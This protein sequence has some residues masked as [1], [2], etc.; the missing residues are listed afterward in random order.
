MKKTIILITLLI[1]TAL[2]AEEG[3]MTNK[4]INESS[5]YL[6]QHSHNPVDWYP[7][8]EE[9]F[10]TAKKEDKPV[11]L[12]IGYST[13]HWC[14]VMEKESFEDADVAELMN[15][16]FI[17][18]KV[19]REERPDIDQVYMNVATMLTGSGG[20]P[21]TIIMTPE[22]E[23]FFAGTYFPKNERFGRIGM[24]E[25]IPQIENAWN[26]K[27]EEIKKT[28]SEIKFSLQ[29]DI[30]K[31][32]KKPDKRII[33]TAFEQLKSRFDK[34]KGGFGSSPKFPSPHNLMFLLRV[35]KNTGNKEALQ[36]VETTMTEMR[37]GGIYDH[38]GFGFHRYSTD[39]D[40]LVPH[41]EKMLYDQAML[42]MAYTE[43][44]EITRKEIYRNTAEEILQYILRDMTSEEGGFY[45]AEDADSEGIEGKFYVWETYELQDILSKEE[46]EFVRKHFATKDAGNFHDEST[47]KKNGKN[48][49]HTLDRDYDRKLWEEIRIKLYTQR[50]NRIHPLKDDKILT[51]WNGLMIAAFAKAGSAFYKPE[52]ISAA[53]K[54]AEFINEKLTVKGKLM[55]RYR[56]GN[57]DISAFVDDYAFLTYGLISLYE[58]TFDLDYLERAIELTEQLNANFYDNEN[59]GYH[60]TSN[61]AEELFTR[62]KDAYDGA[63]PS[64]NSIAL[65]NLVKLGKYTAKTEFHDKADEISKAFGNHLQRAPMGFT[66]FLSAMDYAMNPSSEVIVVGESDNPVTGEMLNIIEEG[67]NPQLVVLHK[68][69]ANAHKLGDIASFTKDYAKIDGKTTVYVC[70]NYNCSLP[71]TKIGELRKLLKK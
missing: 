48:I 4:L 41:F 1:I 56:K 50:E 13:C 21:L 24:M 68:T 35:Y 34:D 20:W 31:G 33:Q 53:K 28:T 51:D 16:T 54:A 10:E 30:K 46:A 27:R 18:I 39:A 42:T 9:A 15:K 22:K 49:L 59:G 19:D 44:Y 58:A 40:W 47:R 32:T 17:N 55:H 36:M 57:T 61:E 12:S 62:T 23:P 64:G 14:H 43:A 2:A 66:Q 29:T 11:F 45:S 26:T 70:K 71:V 25:L 38:V 7:W 60:F 63:Y 69:E 6:L 3:N 5:P 67:F 37:K 8:G 52:Y 65:M